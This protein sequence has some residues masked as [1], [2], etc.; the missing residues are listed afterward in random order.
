VG[1][2]ASLGG[3]IREVALFRD[4]WGIYDSHLPLGARP[5]DYEWE[6]LGQRERIQE[7]IE[8]PDSCQA[9]P[10][11]EMRPSDMHRSQQVVLTSSGWQI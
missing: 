5:A 10:H 2:A 3:L 11:E 7:E 1:A 4:R 6:Q 8:R 9:V